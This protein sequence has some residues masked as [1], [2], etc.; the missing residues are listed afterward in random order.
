MSASHPIHIQS[1]PS[2]NV[3]VR[4]TVVNELNNETYY[5]PNYQE[6]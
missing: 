4:K 1:L 2:S 6:A 5:H 3:I